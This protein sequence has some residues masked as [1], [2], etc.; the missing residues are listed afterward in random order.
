M[1]S[2][3]HPGL[4]RPAAHHGHRGRREWSGLSYARPSA[5]RAMRHEQVCAMECLPASP[6]L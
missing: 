6:F 3:G 4:R 5:L 2:P 1:R